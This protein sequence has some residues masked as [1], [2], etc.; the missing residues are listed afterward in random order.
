[1]VIFW[2]GLFL[3]GLWAMTYFRQSLF[4]TSVLLAAIL[5]L[6]SL[7]AC[8]P[9]V[10]LVPV[11]GLFLLITI[12][13]NVRGLRLAGI[14]AP[15][16]KAF[17]AVM[18]EVSKTEREALEA[19]SVWWES[20]FFKGCPD[21]RRLTALPKPRLRDDEQAF[22]DGPV[23]KLC[24]M[25]DDWQ[26]TEE[27]H[28]LPEAVWKYIREQG[29]FGMIIPKE[30]GG[31]A[32]SALGHS[33]VVMK[34]ASRS[35][36]AA[37]TVMVP[38]SLGPAEL[39]LHYGT[40]EQRN[41]Y[42]PRLAKGD[43]I[44]CFA[45]TGPEAGSDAASIPDYGVVCYG[46]FKRKKVL[47]IRLNWE[48]RYITLGPVA[49]LLGLAFKL[50]DPDKLLGGDEDVGITLAL[51]PTTTP[52]VEIGRRHFPLN[53]VFQ[54][55]PN[56]GRDVFIPMD[57]VIGGQERVGQGWRMLMESLAAGRSISLP[58][59]SAGAGKLATRASVAYARIRQQFKLPIA[60]FEGVEEVLVR[61]IGQAYIMDSA[62]TL[63]TIA[64]DQGEK[65]AVASA[66]VKYQL[67]ERMREVVRDAMD[68]HGGSGICLGPNNVLGRIY[69]S[70]PISI[71][72]EGANILTRTL[73]VFGQGA[74][75]CHPYVFKEM[76][77][78]QDDS[79]AGALQAFDE[80]L[81]GHVGLVASNVARSLWLGLTG[82][83]FLKLPDGLS[84]GYCGRYY[85]NLTRMSV[86]FA[87]L[88][89]FSLAALGGSL[90]R[91]ERLSGRLADVIGNLYLATAAL[92]RFADDGQP[93]ADRPLVAW[94]CEDSLYRIQEAMY[95]LFDNLPNRPLA[96]IA[97]ILIF[98]LGR[99]YAPPSDTLGH[100]LVK[101]FLEPSEARDRLTAG[102]FVPDGAQDALG[103]IEEALGLVIEAG[104]LEKRLREARADGRISPTADYEAQISCAQEAGVLNADE[105]ALLVRAH[106]AIRSVTDV[107]DF[108]QDFWKGER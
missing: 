37:V 20:E 15:V 104:P 3:S 102:I 76:Q 55:G 32:F 84:Q 69:Q 51:I 82:A 21:W 54:N 58:A 18:P 91:R 8:P 63:T 25:L 48:K 1:M 27:E 41:H 4:R 94:A 74:I 101:P 10:L 33:S 67:T 64:V 14:S 80:A 30:Y 66:I 35:I 87:L 99:C 42:L 61:I 50:Y 24:S 57:Y 56:S 36:T 47:G 97:R 92:K 39:L 12:S 6:W 108:P 83:A 107:D 71:T 79:G 28:D 72:V 53:M 81:F 98:P 31:L 88:A 103:R 78:S 23:E 65:P 11:W 17:R 100:S 16:L 95:G 40:E 105:A 68:V 22:L 62:R 5:V 9:G 2:I 43:E 46:K 26:I 49:T 70:V 59:L 60:Y 19:G 73:I 29:F 90:K 86:G 106:K 44:P 93:E 34:V 7:A 52:G 45:L 89:D 85:R 13:L 96:W 75:R 77:A 38:N